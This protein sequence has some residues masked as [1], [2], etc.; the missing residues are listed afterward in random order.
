[1]GVV[2]VDDC[3]MEKILFCTIMSCEW[4]RDCVL[5][6]YPS[7]VLIVIF[8]GMATLLPSTRPDWSTLL[9]SV[10]T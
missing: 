6:D 3:M 4:F 1:M 10:I 9:V 7:F 2:D 8:Y 5:H